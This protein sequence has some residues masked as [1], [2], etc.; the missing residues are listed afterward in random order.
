MTDSQSPIVINHT[1]ANE[2]RALREQQENLYFR[3]KAVLD[4]ETP[5]SR[6]RR[7]SKNKKKYGYCELERVTNSA[8]NVHRIE[9]N[10]LPVSITCPAT[11]IFH[12][13]GILAIISFFVFVFAVLS[14]MVVK[15]TEYIYNLIP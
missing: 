6:N 4:N 1:V 9:Q 5:R 12:L 10:N 7:K 8:L 3:D 13:L 15:T 14:E 2:I 11:D